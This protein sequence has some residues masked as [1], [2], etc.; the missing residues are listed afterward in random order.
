M[1]NEKINIQEVNETT[2]RGSGTSS[3]IAYVPGL[4]LEVSDPEYR[5]CPILFTSVTDFESKFG[6]EPYRMTENDVDSLYLGSNN[7]VYQVGDYDKSYIYA[8]ELLNAGMP[9]I[10]EDIEPNDT[11]RS[12]AKISFVGM[13]APR[14]NQDN[15]LLDVSGS[16]YVEGGELAYDDLLPSQSNLVVEARNKFVY[17]TMNE[18]VHDD[19]I[20]KFQFRLA[21]SLPSSGS[22][23]VELNIPTVEG[24]QAAF[25]AS[26]VEAEYA[27]E[28]VRQKIT[29]GSDKKTITWTNAT[30]EDFM[31]VTFAFS[32]ATQYSGTDADKKITFG[33]DVVSAEDVSSTVSRIDYLYE[34]L[35][36]RLNILQDK[37]EYN[38]KYITSGGYPTFDLES[39]RGDG[40][41]TAMLNCAKNRGDAVGL[42]DHN[43]R[44]EAP[45]LYTD[46]ESVYYKVNN[47][48]QSRDG[49]EYGAMFSPWSEYT[50]S[51]APKSGE[52]K[53]LM[54]ASF[55]YLMCVAK[56][57]KTSPNWL[58]M[59]GVTRGFV[60]NIVKL[61][62]KQT[63]TNVIAENYQPKY[64]SEANR[65]SINAITNIKPYGLTIWGNR[66]LA[67]VQEKGTTALN[68]LNTR[69]MISDIKKLAYSTAK[70]LMFEQDS[71]TL[72]L[73]FKS[74]MSPLLEQ[75][76]SGFGISDYKIIR[77]TT[78]FNGAELTRGELA[79]V[80][81]IFPVYAIEYFEITIVIDDNDVT[82]S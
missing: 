57:I 54:P 36:D 10:Y 56:T 80:I 43:D 73:R 34:N 64:G 27:N 61:H 30:K 48:L 52:S 58:A 18:T 67:P 2:P 78:K 7:G 12:V 35:S 72:W 51:T 71:D 42:I 68:F 81:K 46:S 31:Y 82:I 15:Q 39:D 38:V 23:T 37:S 25:T 44:Y 77:G 59:A 26:G 1:A 9:V 32:L 4:A 6:K 13:K 19:Y 40:I 20:Y 76:K 3:D 63:L 47:A 22:A 69:N 62:T 60:P 75:L 66:T 24:F 45:L 74:S 49:N 65:E 8:K 53:L 16:L 21:N 11:G 33:I 5:N 41:V 55:A 28:S 79:A 14:V 70:S 17:T 50:C 29:V